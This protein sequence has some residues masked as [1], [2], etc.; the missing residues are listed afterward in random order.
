MGSI[1]APDTWLLPVC[2]REMKLIGSE[3]VQY[4]ARPDNLEVLFGRT[5]V[6]RVNRGNFSGT[7]NHRSL[8]T[9][10]QGITIMLEDYPIKSANAIHVLYSVPDSGSHVSDNS[11]N[12]D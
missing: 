2:T 10:M 6:V 4:K 5:R 7:C 3:L 11:Y 9:R 12:G 8:I 1:L